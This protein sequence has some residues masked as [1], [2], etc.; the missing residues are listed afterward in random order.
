MNV[1]DAL[2]D[3]R[4]AIE[5]RSHK[6]LQERLD[7]YFASVGSESAFRI[8]GIELQVVQPPA[9]V[10][11]AFDEIIAAAQDEERAI[12]EAKGD[13]RETIERA[14]AQAIEF[15]QSS[16]GYKAAKVF[17]A[18][19]RATRFEALL[20]EYHLAPEV[21]RR[22]LYLETMEEIL[23][24]VDKLVIE[25][26]SASLLP[27]IQMGVAPGSVAPAPAPVVSPV[28]APAPAAGEREAR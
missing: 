17:E 1:D 7:E 20:T 13:A 3:E 8:R 25:P 16:I 5:A 24:E 15:E 2:Y 23:P 12:S 28:S 22:R 27:L 21:T 26:G 19:G 14:T 18:H 4:Q 11:E 10:Q 9:Q 6:L